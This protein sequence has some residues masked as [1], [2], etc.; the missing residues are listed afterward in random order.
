MIGAP[1]TDVILADCCTLSLRGNASTMQFWSV[2]ALPSAADAAAMVAPATLASPP[3]ADGVFTKMTVNVGPTAALPTAKWTLKTAAGPPRDIP[4]QGGKQSGKAQEPTAEEW[5][6]AAAYT[7]ELVS[8]AAGNSTSATLFRDGPIANVALRLGI[9]YAGDSARMYLGDRCLT[10]NW[11]SGYH[12]DGR[13]EMGLDYLAGENPDMW[14]GKAF[15]FNL[16]PLKKSSLQTDV[17]LQQVLW[18]DFGGK[19][20][21]CDIEA[22]HVIPTYMAS[23]RM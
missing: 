7:V 3:T 5:K 6:A 8:S 11:Y 14:S 18:P 10:D 13:M 4:K 1:E 22:I 23:M 16:M 15:T 21:V 9:D 19:D 17:F 2:P 20:A 12:T